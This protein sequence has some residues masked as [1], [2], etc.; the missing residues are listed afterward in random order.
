MRLNRRDCDN[1][2]ERVCDF[3]NL[4]TDELTGPVV[5]DTKFRRRLEAF[6]QYAHLILPP[7]PLTHSFPRELLYTKDLIERLASRRYLIRWLQYAADRREID[8]CKMRLTDAF[9]RLMVRIP[10]S[11]TE[12][13]FLTPFFFA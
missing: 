9:E 1:L 4:I 3:F 7:H 13:V 11:P 12:R 5:V 2:V 6:Q 8:D 10:L